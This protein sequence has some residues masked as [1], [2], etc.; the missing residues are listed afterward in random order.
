[1]GAMTLINIPVIIILSKYAIGALADYEKQRK[2][3]K[4]PV[5]KAES[6]NLPDKV[7]YWQ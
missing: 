4:H 3:G 6:V 2:E 7:D 5:F 1:M